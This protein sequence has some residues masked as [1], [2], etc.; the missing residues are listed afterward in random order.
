M[1]KGLF[2]SLIAAVAMLASCNKTL[3]NPDQITVNP[4]PLEVKG[5]KV[6]ADITGTFPEKKFVKK[7]VLVVTP[8]L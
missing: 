3:P 5:G 2:L 8:V 7:G 4:S 6:N 1:K